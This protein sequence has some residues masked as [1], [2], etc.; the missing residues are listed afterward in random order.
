ME[1]RQKH[2]YKSKLTTTNYLVLLVVTLVFSFGT[3]FFLKEVKEKF[4]KEKLEASQLALDAQL[5]LRNENFDLIGQEMSLITTDTGDSLSKQTSLN[6]NFAAGFVQM[7][8]DAKIQKGDTIA[9]AVTGSFP[10]I[11]IALYSAMKVLGI[12]PVIISSVGASQ[13]GANQ[14]GE[15]WLDF[16]NLLFRKKIFPFKSVAASLGGKS[17]IASDVSIEG[18]AVL[19][20]VITT[21]GI[22]Y[23][24]VTSL[25]E[26]IN[27]RTETYNKITSNYK[28]FVNIGGG[29]A[30]LGIGNLKFAPHGLSLDLF[31]VVFPKDG[32]LPRMA[33]R[34]IPIIHIAE[35]ISIEKELGLKELNYIVPRVG[36]GEIFSQVKYELL[37]LVP[38]AIFYWAI[39]F[40]LL[41]RFR[42]TAIKK[43]I[44]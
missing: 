8:K 20:N 34:G 36:K 35:V 41:K 38:F 14:V 44:G 27:K 29:V 21:S 37:Y 4:Y 9:V 2:Y 23:I 17:D 10:A 1:E 12:K 40:F 3:E 42:T 32:V 15:T 16:E 43:A 31:D 22:P 39:I 26:S 13:W 30:S 11:N 33:E 28:M 19:E 25:E 18:R 7:F 5:V 24:N 6:P